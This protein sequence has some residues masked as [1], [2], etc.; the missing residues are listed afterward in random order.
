LRLA[1]LTFCLQLMYEKRNP[2]FGVQLKAGML[3]WIK[4]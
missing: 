2:S 4:Y 1:F 3:V